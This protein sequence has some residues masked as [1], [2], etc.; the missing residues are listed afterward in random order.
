MEYAAR[1]GTETPFWTGGCIDTDQANYNGGHDYNGCGAKT[2]WSRGRTVPVGR[3]PAN[4]W[5][6]HEVAGNVWEWTDSD[7]E[8]S[9][10]FLRGGS[11]YDARAAARCASRCWF[12]PCGGDGSI[13]F[14]C[15]R[16]IKIA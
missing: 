13:G 10:K 6:L 2:G 8:G 11:W 15:A 14:R 12:D 5:G 4:P 9:I 3:L 7:K 1:A 16:T